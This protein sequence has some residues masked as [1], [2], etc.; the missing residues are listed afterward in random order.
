LLQDPSTH[1]V[2]FCKTNRWWPTL[3]LGQ[4]LYSHA[5]S[6]KSLLNVL[7]FSS[8][9]KKMIV[10]FSLHIKF[11]TKIYHVFYHCFIK[12]CPHKSLNFCSLILHI[13]NNYGQHFIIDKI[14]HMTSHSCPTNN[15]LH[16]IMHSANPLQVAFMW[17]GW[18]HFWHHLSTFWKWTHFV[19]ELVLGSNILGCYHIDSWTSIQV[20]YQYS[21]LLNDV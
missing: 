11:F 14:K 12:L 13:T 3:V 8:Y 4:S 19:H 7:T 10:I 20:C 18:F 9:S 16:I 1:L 15:M 21:H 6:Q 5:Y 2:E 17:W